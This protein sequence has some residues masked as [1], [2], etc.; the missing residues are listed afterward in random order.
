MMHRTHTVISQ[1]ELSA[2]LYRLT[3]TYP[4]ELEPPKPGQ[5]LTIRCSRRTDPLLRRP[6]AFSGYSPEDDSAEILYL[7]R[8][9]A[10]TVLAAVRP[11]E[12]VD[13]IAPLGNTFPEITGTAFLAG[14]G[15][16]IGPIVFLANTL[17][18]AQRPYRAVIGFRTNTAV[19]P[20]SY[21]NEFSPDLCT[22][23]GTA[24]YG[25][26]VVDFTR[27][28]WSSFEEGDCVIACGPKP[29]L[30]ALH[31]YSLKVG[32][33]LYVSMEQV[34]A[35]GVGAC[36]G[37]VV[38]TTGNRRYARVCSEGPVFNSGEILWSGSRETEPGAETRPTISGETQ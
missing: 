23:D 3:F 36:M 17:R 24:G 35:C 12:P 10:T 38:E 22:D 28:R 32:V 20:E 6:F 33:S 30:A 13:C 11:G 5:F 4:P 7:R 29:M 37:C 27:E 25:G 8:G 15:I 18:R 14:G 9:P 1:T 19:P 2:D 21:L 34:M 16:G 26:T 31:R